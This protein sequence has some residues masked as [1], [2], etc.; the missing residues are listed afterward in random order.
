MARYDGLR[1][2][3][4]RDRPEED[5]AL[6]PAARG[7]QIERRRQ[8]DVGNG[9]IEHDSDD[10]ELCRRLRADPGAGVGECCGGGRQRDDVCERRGE[11]R[12]H[13]CA[14]ELRDDGAGVFVG[15]GGVRG[16]ALGSRSSSS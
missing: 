10:G 4:Y 13:D 9:R 7:G 15:G 6:N 11:R 16:E 8:R 14:C 3:H 2:R 1:P 5:R 12:V